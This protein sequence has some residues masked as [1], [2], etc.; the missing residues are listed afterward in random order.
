MSDD[1]TNILDADRIRELLTELGRRLDERGLSARLFVVGGGA[2]ALAYN[3]RR[4]TRDLDGVF[5]PK[6]EV[7]AEAAAMAVEHGL[8]AD[9]LNDGVKGLLP[10][11]A[12]IEEGAHFEAAGIDVGVASA[13]YLFAMKASAARETADAEDLRFLADHL[14]LRNAAEALDLVDRFYSPHRLRPASHLFVETLFDRPETAPAETED[15]DVSTA[16][17]S[18]PPRSGDGRVSPY[19]RKDGTLVK[20]HNRRQS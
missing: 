3:S 4:V 5:E 8:P 19:R 18:R 7:Y 9:W 1:Q 2:M 11:R 13:E 12:P 14:G 10:D 16:E 6:T 15:I 17:P 20:G